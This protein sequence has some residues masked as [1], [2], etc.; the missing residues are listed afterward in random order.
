MRKAIIISILM[1]LALPLL[2][3]HRESL[4]AQE[5]TGEVIRQIW[6]RIDRRV[7]ELEK[8]TNLLEQEKG[9]LLKEL[10][11]KYEAFEKER[12]ELKKEDLATDLLLINA[13]LNNRD[14]KEVEACLGT[15]SQLIPDLE[16]LKQEFRTGM[17]FYEGKEEFDLTRKKMGK[18]MTNMACILDGLKDSVSPEARGDI[19]ILENTLIGIY[20]CW[21]FSMGNPVVSLDHIDETKRQLEDAFAQ[22]V[23]VKRLL[24]QEKVNLKVDN[25]L[26]LARL[27]L[28][29]LEKG[30]LHTGP[31]FER[32][33]EMLKGIRER[34][35][36]MNEVRKRGTPFSSSE[37]SVEEPRALEDRDTLNRIREGRYGWK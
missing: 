6:N 28:I 18:V 21:D 3:Q 11:E 1:L 5:R 30:K 25:L 15:L 13:R 17:G 2:G 19:E 35:K 8:R 24:E 33:K 32:P 4:M 36:V 14:I 16:R 10:H 31:F 29:R 12:D 37:K 34:A 27:T 20:R 22:L 26:A 9:N 7:T 23:N